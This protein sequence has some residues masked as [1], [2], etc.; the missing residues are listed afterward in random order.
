MGTHFKGELD[1]GTGTEEYLGVG[2]QV[3]EDNARSQV[4]VDGGRELRGH[5][6]VVGE[7]FEGVT[8]GG[9]GQEQAGAREDIQARLRR[10]LEVIEMAT[11]T[12]RTQRTRQPRKFYQAGARENEERP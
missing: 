12:N 5:D 8:G 6:I 11:W 3:Q 9:P 7:N 4:Q 1:I 10:A 2:W